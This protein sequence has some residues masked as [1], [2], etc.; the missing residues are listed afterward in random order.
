[1]LDP[2]YARVDAFFRDAAA[3]RPGAIACGPRCDGCCRVDLSVFPVEAERIAAA[4]AALPPRTRAAAARRA[5]SGRHCA[6]LHPRRRQCVVYPAR[7]LI[8]RTHGLAILA[9]GRLDHCPLN[10]RDGPTDRANVLVLDRV[11]EPLALADRLSGGTGARVRIAAIAAAAVAL[12]CAGTGGG[13]DTGSDASADPAPD[14][15]ADAIADSV[16]DPDAAADVT[17][18]TPSTS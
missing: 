1:M 12:A 4:F 10:Y 16:T 17:P 6:M 14:V 2:L 13:A 7:P 8:C 9:D 15:I 3:A 5:E 18:R 11:N